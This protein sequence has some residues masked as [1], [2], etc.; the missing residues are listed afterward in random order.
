MTLATSSTAAGSTARRAPVGRVRQVRPVAP[1]RVRRK[2]ERGH[3]S[4]RSERSSDGRSGVFG[5]VFGRV[6]PSDPCRHV[7][8]HGL[9]VGLELRVVLLV[10]RGVL[11]DDVDDRHLALAR[12]VQVRQPVTEPG[13][14]VEKHRSGLFL[15]TGVPVG[16]SRHD[17]FEQAEDTTHLGNRVECGDEVHLGRAGVHEACVDAACDERADEC[18]RAV[19]GASS[20]SKIL[21]GLRMPAGRT[22]A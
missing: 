14:E 2:D 6:G 17:A 20:T 13:T 3:L 5:D 4:G 7:A 18:F 15:D 11:A 8:R 9:D 1:R 12:I 16:G 10:V 22:P 19:H 21:P